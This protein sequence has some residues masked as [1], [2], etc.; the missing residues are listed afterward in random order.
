MLA[1]GEQQHELAA[2]VRDEEPVA[3]VRREVRD[4]HVRGQRQ[5]DERGGEAGDQEQTA[6]GLG[7]GDERGH[8]IGRGDAQ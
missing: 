6:G 7:E 1:G 8:Q 4:E 5:A 3:D 2:A